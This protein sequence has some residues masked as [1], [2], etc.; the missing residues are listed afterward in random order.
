MTLMKTIEGEDHPRDD[1]VS[2]WN[3]FT[4]KIHQL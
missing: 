3:S 2:I 1:A 4:K